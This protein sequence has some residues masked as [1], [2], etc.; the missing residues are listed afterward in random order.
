MHIL[1]P[2]IVENLRPPK[3]LQILGGGEGVGGM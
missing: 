3:E 2:K 1:F